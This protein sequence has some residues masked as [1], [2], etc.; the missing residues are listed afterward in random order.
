MSAAPVGAVVGLYYDAPCDVVAGDAIV[1]TTGRTYLVVS[2]RCQRRGK[3]V[4]RWH[5]R[6]LVQRAA[7]PGAHVHPLRWYPRGRRR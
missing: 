7:P 1:T 4:G 6:C 3:H 2:V 5:L